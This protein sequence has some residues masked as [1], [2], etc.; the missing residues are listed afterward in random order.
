[1][2]SPTQEKP[3]MVGRRDAEASR[4][5]II[6]AAIELFAEQGYGASMRDIATQAGVTRS[7][8]HHH[9]ESKDGLWEA[10][11][12]A[13]FGQ[14]I[15][16]QRSLLSTDNPDASQGR[17]SL[18]DY[19][20]FL[21][22]NPNLVRIMCWVYARQNRLFGDDD[23]GSSLFRDIVESFDTLNDSADKEVP[24]EVLLQLIIAGVEHWFMTSGWQ[25][26]VELYDY[27]RE[28]A[29]A[30]YLSAIDRLL[31]SQFRPKDAR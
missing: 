30:A 17:S 19:A 22:N 10:V 23:I 4:A 11:K 20:T 28:T 21:Q 29:Q 1:M 7:L 8:I 15:E 6:E 24:T 5:Q 13:L 12:E 14:F 18:E 2:A 26:L 25:M 27:D 3:R 9:F 31:L 16:A